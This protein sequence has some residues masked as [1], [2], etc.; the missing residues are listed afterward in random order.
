MWM[1]LLDLPFD[2]WVRQS[3]LKIGTKTCRLIEIDVY[4]KALLKG[5]FARVCIAIDVSMP[6]VPGVSPDSSEESD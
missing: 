6:L 2:Y 3:I 1:R 4:T 5:A